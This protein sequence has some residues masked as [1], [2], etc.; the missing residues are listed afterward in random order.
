MIAFGGGNG[1]V[2]ITASED[3]CVR[4]GGKVLVGNTS[5]GPECEAPDLGIGHV[6]S[7]SG[8]VDLESVGNGHY[9]NRSVVGDICPLGSSVDG[10][11][12]TCKTAYKGH[13]V[14]LTDGD[15]AG[16]CRLPDLDGH[17]VVHI[18]LGIIR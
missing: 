8:L 7:G 17:G 4:I 5:Y 13:G 6:V 3:Q 11:L 2:S 18:G 16:R 1:D 14:V 12:Q 9:G 15:G 10:V